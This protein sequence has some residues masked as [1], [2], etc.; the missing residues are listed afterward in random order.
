M[1]PAG[2]DRTGLIVIGASARAAV[3]SA[4]RAGFAPYWIDQFGDRDLAERFPGARVAPEEYPGGI[5]E[6]MRAAPD[7]PFL[8]TGAME[9]HVAVLQ[10]LAQLRPLLGNDAATCAAVRDP[11]RFRGCC[12]A[13]GIAAPEVRNGSDRVPAGRWL[14]KPLASGG[15][16]GIAPAGAGGSPDAGSYLQEFVTGENLSGVFVADGTDAALL[17]V[18]LQ[19]VGRP[20]FHAPPFAYCGSIGPLPLSGAESDQWRTLGRALA[21]EFGMRGLFG[22]DAV[23]RRDDVIPVEINPRYTASVE[24]HELA[25]GPATIALHTA[26][27]QGSLPPVPAFRRSGLVAKAH[28]FAPAPLRVP[29]GPLAEAWARADSMEL[30]DVPRPGTLIRAGAPILTVLVRGDDEGACARLLTVSARRLYQA[31]A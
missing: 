21:R 19:L 10:R 25:G 17:G 26:A 20:E 5:V 1:M 16:M 27:C 3:Y 6:L 14:R 9:N 13:A 2:M 22:I 4:L 11:F 7:A 18:S 28:L 24:V 15:G 31:L 12:L 23:R 29:D 30:A 8:Y